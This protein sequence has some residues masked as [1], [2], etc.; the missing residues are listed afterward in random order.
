M[1]K[2]LVGAFNTLQHPVK[3]AADL[4]KPVQKI[5]DLYKR[6]LTNNSCPQFR[7]KVTVRQR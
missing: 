7:Y 3:T 5:S 1:Y 2:D 4:K 6:R